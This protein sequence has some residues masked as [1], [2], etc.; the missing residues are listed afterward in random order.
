MKF[1]EVFVFVFDFVFVF[2][3]WSC[4]CTYYRVPDR[5]GAGWEEPVPAHQAHP[6]G[7]GQ[8]RHVPVPTPTASGTVLVSN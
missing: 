3:I 4:I 7:L 5:L 2:T 8:A 6:S 1:F